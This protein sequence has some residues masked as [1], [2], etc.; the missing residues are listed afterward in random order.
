M[1]GGLGFFLWKR[2]KKIDSRRFIVE[3]KLPVEVGQVIRIFN[4]GIDNTPVKN[5]M[6]PVRV[7]KK[8]ENKKLLVERTEK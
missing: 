6:I 3:F 8:L 1:S 7:V 4:R 5:N 2:K